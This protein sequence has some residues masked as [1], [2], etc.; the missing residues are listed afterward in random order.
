MPMSREERTAYGRGYNAGLRSRWPETIPPRPPDEVVGKMFDAL[1][2][3][4][5]AVDGQMSTFDEDDEMAVYL[6][7]FVDQAD[8]AMRALSQSVQQTVGYRE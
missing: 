2:A 1:L 5:N 3:L 6:Y 4:R 7:R 8:E